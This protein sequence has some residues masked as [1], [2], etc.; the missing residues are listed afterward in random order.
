MKM[1][2]KARNLGFAF[3]LGLAFYQGHKKGVQL[4]QDADK[5]ITVKP[6]GANNKG[7]PVRIDD[8]TGEIKAGMGGKFN[9]QKI[10]EIRKD[11]VGPKRSKEQRET[12]HVDKLFKGAMSRVRQIDNEKP[13]PTEIRKR[14][15]NINSEIYHLEKMV[16]RLSQAPVEAAAKERAEKVIDLLLAE[17]EKT[18]DIAV[19]AAG[20]VNPYRGKVEQGRYNG[21]KGLEKAESDLD[22]IRSRAEHYKDSKYGD[23]MVSYR[24]A[25]SYEEW[26]SR[27]IDERKTESEKN[28]RARQLHTAI[29]LG[30]PAVMSESEYLSSKGVSEH[31][32]WNIDKVRIPH[33]ETERQKRQ[34]LKETNKKLDEHYSTLKSAREEYRQKL[35]NGE[36]KAPSRIEQYLKAAQGHEDNAATH[37]ARRALT[38]RGIDWKTGNKLS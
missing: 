23:D 27:Y 7:V 11:F 31:S 30:Q 18:F 24:V 14:V 32:D 20:K 8:S 28:A 6:N 13:S 33:G 22:T 35:A 9:G 29:P 19:K 15:T 25:K 5:W 37:A 10:N 26:L 16:Q 36:I 3:S 34:R 17:R 2:N 38:K 12:A 1:T 4:A 21:Q